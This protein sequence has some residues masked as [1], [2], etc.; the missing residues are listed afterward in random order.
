M[1]IDED[2]G[3]DAEKRLED[4]G[5]GHERFVRR[6]LADGSRGGHGRGARGAGPRHG[7]RPGVSRS[8]GS[9]SPASAT[10]SAPHSWVW[11]AGG[12]GGPSY[13]GQGVARRVDV[14]DHARVADLEDPV[15]GPTR[16]D[17]R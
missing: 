4:A 16:R 2:R 12:S 9:G 5:P 1:A 14:V 3:D 17:L 13:V 11:P 7:G 6:A 8:S 10:T 15:S